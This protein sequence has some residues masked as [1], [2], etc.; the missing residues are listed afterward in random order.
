MAQ[1]MK[2]MVFNGPKK[3]K[4]NIITEYSYYLF[5]DSQLQVFAAK[6]TPYCTR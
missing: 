1:N 4:H 3:L 6:Q 5:M 2:K